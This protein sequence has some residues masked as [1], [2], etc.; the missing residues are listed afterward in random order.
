[1]KIIGQTGSDYIVSMTE[2]EIAAAMGFGPYASAA[3]FRDATTGARIGAQ[4]GGALIP[5]AT[6]DVLAAHRIISKIAERTTEIQ[7]IAA[8]LN[9]LAEIITTPVAD[10]LALPPEEP[11]EGGA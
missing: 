10:L 6:L 2:N 11:K 7:K 1:M 5:G 3:P 4:Y 9:A 8:H